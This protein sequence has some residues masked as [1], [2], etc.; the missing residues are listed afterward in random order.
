MSKIFNEIANEYKKVKK[1]LDKENKKIK[2]KIK[3]LKILRKNMP[4][5]KAIFKRN[6][7]VNG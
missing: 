1:Q 6:R 2:N 7:S 5:M 4:R 3:I